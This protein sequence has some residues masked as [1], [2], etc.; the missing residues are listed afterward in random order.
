MIIDHIR[1]DLF[2]IGCLGRSGSRS[3]ADIIS[4]YYTDLMTRAMTIRFLYEPFNM[5]E[6][7]R[8]IFLKGID[9]LDMREIAAV[10]F[11]PH[12][13]YSQNEIDSYNKYVFK[14]TP[15]ILVLRNPVERAKSG[16]FLKLHPDFH[17]E[18][19]L[20]LIDMTTVDYVIDFNQLSEYTGNLKIGNLKTDEESMLFINAE[21]AKLEN[22]VD[23]NQSDYDYDLDLEIYHNALDTLEHLPVDMWKHLVR[24]VNYLNVPTRLPNKRF[25]KWDS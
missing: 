20:S 6:V 24:N 3:I 23:W 11:I 4:A 1:T 7:E 8:G 5:S 10:G 12:H 21:L 18:P 25:K 13:P 14:S 9:N 17:G 19:V 22:L 16:S 2:S 15:K